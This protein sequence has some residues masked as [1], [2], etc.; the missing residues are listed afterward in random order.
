MV[1]QLPA[2]WRTAP[3]SDLK[4]F[5]QI[6]I[7]LCCVGCGSGDTN[8]VHSTDV[9]ECIDVSCAKCEL[10][11][12]DLA[13]NAGDGEVN[14][15][16]SRSVVIA[17]HDSELTLVPTSGEKVQRLHCMMRRMACEMSRYK[18]DR[19]CNQSRTVTVYRYLEDVNSEHN[20]RVGHYL[21][22]IDDYWLNGTM[23]N[24]NG[25]DYFDQQN[26]DRL[27]MSMKVCSN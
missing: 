19:I 17:F 5:V 13:F 10:D 2:G 6:L 21:I 26:G 7:P 27:F 15:H 25:R 16:Q 14:T 9:P 12:L 11:L 22:N 4:L 24:R 1:N 8:I 3:F 18:I 20:V 23:F